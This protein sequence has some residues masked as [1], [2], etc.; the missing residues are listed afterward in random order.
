MPVTMTWDNAEKTIIR[1]IIEGQW[2]VNDLHRL[3]SQ[4]PT[5][6]AEVSHIVDGIFDFSRSTSTPTSALMT[7]SRMEAA[8]NDR[9][10]LF[11]VVGA[12]SYIQTLCNIAAKLAPKTFSKLMFVETMNDAYAAINKHTNSVRA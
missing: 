2:D 1:V 7:L 10:R 3:I 9:Q 12:N 5:M 6:M 11:I 8:Y 4:A